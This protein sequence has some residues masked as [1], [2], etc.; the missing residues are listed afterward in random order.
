MVAFSWENSMNI[1]KALRN[2]RKA[3]S[4]RLNALDSAIHALS[5]EAIKTERKIAKTVKRTMSAATRAKISKAAKNRW[6]A[7]A[8]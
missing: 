1:V 7:I 6:A 2:E 3:L 8:R 4:K 5:D